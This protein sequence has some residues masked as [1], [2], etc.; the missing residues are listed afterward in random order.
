MADQVRYPTRLEY[1]M[2][3]FSEQ[4]FFPQIRDS[5]YP[6]SSHSDVVI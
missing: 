1:I 4:L 3:L 5:T 6:L 2:E